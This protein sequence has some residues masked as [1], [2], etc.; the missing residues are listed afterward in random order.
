MST[1]ILD[2]DLSPVYTEVMAATRPEDVF[3]DLTGVTAESKVPALKEQYEA[4][5]VVLNPKVYTRVVDA[6]AASD[7]L[8]ELERLYKEA[9]T[10]LCSTLANVTLNINGTLYDVLE[11]LAY[12]EHSV[13]YKALPQA[14]HKKGATQNA[15]VLKVAKSNEHS[16]FLAREAEHLRFFQ[17]ANDRHPIA[18][19]RR[20]LPKLLDS[21]NYQGREILV[22]PFYDGYLSVEDIRS[23][24]HGSLPAGHAAWIARRLLAFPLTAAMAGLRHEA[25]NL[26]HLLVHP[27]THEPLYLGWSHATPDRAL[28]ERFPVMDLRDTF[29]LILHLFQDD[30]N[31]IVEDVPPKLVGYLKQ[32]CR[33]TGEVDGV[34]T[35]SEFTELIYQELGK[36][37]RPLKLKP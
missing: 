12:G 21:L 9:L 19:V 26:N 34:N 20:T 22:L 23:Y 8:L 4:L 14:T 5:K 11:R 15:V 32:Q 36:K 16:P 35:I 29:A 1:D 33:E 7:A 10:L 3:G 24:F 27:I 28:Q 30:R 17:G 25:M 31:V 37:Y 2:S 18:G 6:A 13:L